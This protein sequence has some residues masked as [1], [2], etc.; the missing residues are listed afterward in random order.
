MRTS[1]SWGRSWRCCRRRVAG[2]SPTGPPRPRCS[3]PPSRSCAIPSASLPGRLVA[4]FRPP[5]GGPSCT[6]TLGKKVPSSGG[7]V[8]A[9]ITPFWP[10]GRLDKTK[11]GQDPEGATRRPGSRRRWNH[12]RPTQ[13]GPPGASDQRD[14]LDLKGLRHACL[15]SELIC[16]PPVEPRATESSCFAPCVPMVEGARTRGRATTLGARRRPGLRWG[17]HRVNL[18]RT[19]VD[20]LGVVVGDVVAREAA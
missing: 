18:P 5:T 13:R 20:P 16:V 10:I 8:H 6:K 15:S 9:W 1:S 7:S 14:E 11:N 4:P 2:A 19:R 17:A 12:D 3:A